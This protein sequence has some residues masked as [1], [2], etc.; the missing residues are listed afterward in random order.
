MKKQLPN[1]QWLY[2]WSW[3][4]ISYDSGIFF[5]YSKLT[6]EIIN[7]WISIKYADF[8]GRNFMKQIQDFSYNKQFNHTH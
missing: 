8:F 5:E 2:S 6:A 7:K 1:D 4:L 3:V